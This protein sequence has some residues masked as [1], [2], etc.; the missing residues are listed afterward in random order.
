MK[1]FEKY[2][3]PTSDNFKE[4]LN[5]P[6]I[7]GANNVDYYFDVADGLMRV[8]FQ[9]TNSSLNKVDWEYDLDFF[10]QKFEIYPGTNIRAHEG[11]A[12][13]YYAA[14]KDIL[15]R[16]YKDDVKQIIVMGYSLGAA[17]VQLCVEDLCFHFPTG[18]DIYG[19]AYEPPRAFVL[20]KGVKAT[21]KDHVS[22]IGSRGDIVTHV[23]CSWWGFRFYGKKV[24]IGHWYDVFKW[25]F[26]VWAHI[27]KNVEKNLDA[28]NK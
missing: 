13:Q 23:P 24:H 14:R 26:F 4:I 5:A 21:I 3:K 1:T 18:R 16:A 27:Q 28:Y 17:L 2:K 10:G 22:L 12:Q 25:P 7:H 19:M 20:N 15:N 6:Y 9:P 11:F 8:F